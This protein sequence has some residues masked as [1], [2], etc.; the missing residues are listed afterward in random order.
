MTPLILVGILVVAFG[1]A[2]ARGPRV[3]LAWVFFPI[4]FCIPEEIT[5]NIPALPNLSPRRAALIGLVLGSLVNGS[6]DKLIPRW[7]PF[8]LLPLA[9]IVSLSVSY[10][11]FTDLLGFP[12]RLSVLFL[13]WFLPYMLVRALWTDW[14]RVRDALL[15]IGLACVFLAASSVYE[16][17]MATRITRQF[18]GAL[19][20]LWVPG[21]VDMWRWG[22][23]RAF[24]TFSHPITLGVTFSCMVPLMILWGQLSPRYRTHAQ[25]AA[26]SCAAGCVTALSRGPIV[27]MILGALVGL[28]FARRRSLTWVAVGAALLVLVPF[29]MEF[30][31]SA[32]A[33][34]QQSLDETGN[35]DSG[36]YRLALFMLYG[37]QIGS[38]GWFGD[39]SPIGAAFEQAWSID[40]AYLYL[41]FDGG[42]LG[43]G[44]IIAICIAGLSIGFRTLARHSGRKRKAAACVLASF[45]AL[46]FGMTDVWFAADYSPLLFILA[47]LIRNQSLRSWF[48]APTTAPHPHRPRPL[49][50]STIA[51]PRPLA[52]RV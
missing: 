29:G 51:E 43:A 42:W 49:E 52:A 37:T 10:A 2:T 19:T 47:A 38:V 15:P 39:H 34:A 26:I 25:I 30:L 27:G 20:G 44:L 21:H 17:R 6:G 18:W 48:G 24:G 14:T 41:F 50:P 7:R 8:D 46:L 12:H 32:A 13:D 4:F 40:N 23:L 11:R 3:A 9:A 35:V 16:C 1:V 28:M 33:T 45:V 22:F 31:S 36:H 5:Q